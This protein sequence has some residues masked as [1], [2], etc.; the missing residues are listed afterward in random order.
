MPP[1]ASADPQ[2][3]GDV[4]DLISAIQP[5]QERLAGLSKQLQQMEKGPGLMDKL[6]AFRHGGV[7]NAM[8]KLRDQI[9]DVQ[10]EMFEKLTHGQQ[11]DSHA[12]DGLEAHGAEALQSEA[13]RYQDQLTVDDHFKQAGMPGVLNEA[14]RHQVEKLL[15]E[16]AKKLSAL[17]GE[18]EQGGPEEGV[19][20]EKK[21]S[22][23]QA[24]GT[25]PKA[26]TGPA[27]EAPRVRSQSL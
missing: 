6:K 7:E 18:Q 26:Q 5:D 10:Q 21:V 16:N 3:A 27:V 24:L 13:T 17:N 12:A 15:R 22:V 8:E 20:I 23:R 14:Q 25:G 11:S 2:T 19:D 4:H 1:A 9:A